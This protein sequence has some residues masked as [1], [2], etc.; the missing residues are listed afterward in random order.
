MQ[1]II[2]KDIFTQEGVIEE[3]SNPTQDELMGTTSKQEKP[4]QDKPVS[5]KPVQVNTDHIPFELFDTFLS[6]KQI[7]PAV[8]AKE[9]EDM[10]KGK[11]PEFFWSVKDFIEKTGYFERLKDIL[12]NPV[13]IQVEELP[14]IMSEGEPPEV[15]P[16]EPAKGLS[17]ELKKEA[18]FV[19]MNILFISDI[20]DE[21]GNL[22]EEKFD[23]WFETL[24]LKG[25]KIHNLFIGRPAAEEECKKHFL[26]EVLGR[27]G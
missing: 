24:E 22:L 2:K 13:G 26:K 8:I 1:N 12:E 4:M 6:K 5:E 19:G 3:Q 14:K 23:N 21:D 9:T 17:R 27:G 16:K 20:F 15:Q 11:T 7:D 18:V 10:I 25:K